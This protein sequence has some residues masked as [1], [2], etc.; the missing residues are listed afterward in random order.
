MKVWFPL[1]QLPVWC[2]FLRCPKVQPPPLGCSDRPLT[3]ARGRLGLPLEWRSSWWAATLDSTTSQEESA[4]EPGGAEVPNPGY[5]IQPPEELSDSRCTP[6]LL[7]PNVWVW[8]PDTRRVLW[9]RHALLTGWRH[10]PARQPMSFRVLSWHLR[11]AYGQMG[12]EV[13]TSRPVDP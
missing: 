3:L 8:G 10:R 9:F 1:V 6:D 2:G 11:C 12:R 7:N 5:A 13:D 4:G